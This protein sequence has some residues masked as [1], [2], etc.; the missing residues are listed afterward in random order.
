MSDPFAAG[1][2]VL[3]SAACSAAAVYQPQDGAPRMVQVISSRPSDDMRVGTATIIVATAIF[4]LR[5]A[6]V[7]R[8]QHGDR[9][10]LGAIIIEGETVGGEWFEL[11]GEPLLD[12][13]NLTWSIGGEPA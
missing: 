6:E 2:D 1:L 5:R 8:P 3:F 10:G 4:E 7:D 9:L 13:E 12:V 11:S